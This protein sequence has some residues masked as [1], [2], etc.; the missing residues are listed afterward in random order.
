MI[1]TIVSVGVAF[2]IVSFTSIG[3]LAILY[4]FVW[5][6]PCLIKR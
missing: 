6:W 3:W 2:V 1:A 5:P 4:M